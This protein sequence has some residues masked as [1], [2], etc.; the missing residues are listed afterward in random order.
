[1]AIPKDVVIK[2]TEDQR[3]QIKSATGKEI[4]ELK[5]AAPASPFEVKPAL[6][7]RANPGMLYT[8]DGDFDGC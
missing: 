4:T 1:M 6:E 3:N 8:E 5:V 2:L 7:D